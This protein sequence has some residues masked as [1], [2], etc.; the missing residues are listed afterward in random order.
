[1]NGKELSGDA[2]HKV[3][4]PIPSDCTGQFRYPRLSVRVC[5]SLGG[6]CFLAFAF[7]IFFLQ[8]IHVSSE[9]IGVRLESRV[10]SY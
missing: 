2:D 8:T 1:M 4:S 3:S 6:F 9:E 7:L 10:Y 5:C